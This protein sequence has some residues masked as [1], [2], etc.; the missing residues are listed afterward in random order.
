MATFKIRVVMQPE[1]RFS[2]DE[3]FIASFMPRRERRVE[4][5]TQQSFFFEASSLEE[6]EKKI[7]DFLTKGVGPV[8]LTAGNVWLRGA[9]KTAHSIHPFWKIERID[10]VEME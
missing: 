9:V 7:T 3:S 1:S 4:H 5:K 6:T 2:E 8:P 10:V